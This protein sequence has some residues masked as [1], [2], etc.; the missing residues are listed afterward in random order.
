MWRERC[1]FNLNHYMRNV[2]KTS[3]LQ[4][5][6]R[7]SY[8]EAKQQGNGLIHCLWKCQVVQP[9]KWEIQQHPAKLHTQLY[10]N[11]AIPFVGSYPKGTLE[12]KKKKKDLCTRPFNSKSENNPVVHQH[13]LVDWARCG[14][15][16]PWGRMPR[17]RR[18]ESNY[19]MDE[20]GKHYVK[21]KKPAQK[22][23]KC[24]I[25]FKWNVQNG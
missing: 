21:K 2:Y 8:T 9:L 11:P 12:K 20:P 1:P 24:M 19:D 7:K 14:G 10:L 23:T 22:A 13:G 15:A 16:P 18:T 25:P 17:Q 4:W 3:K 5:D 6:T